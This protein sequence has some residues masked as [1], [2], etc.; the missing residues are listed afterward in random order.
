ML[1]VLDGAR[2]K[3]GLEEYV[4]LRYSPPS[5]ACRLPPGTP[6]SP[7]A[8]S[9][10][11]PAQEFGQWTTSP[12]R[13]SVARLKSTPL[14]DFPLLLSPAR[15]DCCSSRR[16]GRLRHAITRTATSSC[17]DPSLLKNWYD[18]PLLPR[19]TASTGGR[20][21]L[22]ATSLCS[23]RWHG[24]T[25]CSSREGSTRLSKHSTT[26]Q[27]TGDISGWTRIG[28]GRNL[29]SNTMRGAE[30][31]DKPLA[32]LN[33]D[34]EIFALGLTDTPAD[35]ERS[36]LLKTLQ[37]LRDHCPPIDAFNSRQRVLDFNAFGTPSS[38]QPPV[39][40][41][42]SYS[43]SMQPPPSTSSTYSIDTDSR[44]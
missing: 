34:G 21:R 22:F 35:S 7:D 27:G 36:L 28:T 31:I 14:C 26:M 42:P 20:V 30:D 9:A 13:N 15:I 44:T 1:E 16:R 29:V 41:Q 10:R 8:R 37:R 12:S 4:P 39:P 33:G 19:A 18:G 5:S 24:S 2:A 32:G 17:G 43:I 23:L 11:I 3:K 6:V 40:Q 38:R 25:C